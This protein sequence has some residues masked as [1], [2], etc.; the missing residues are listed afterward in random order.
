[1]AAAALA[2]AQEN[3]IDLPV[4]T[5]IVEEEAVAEAQ[6]PLIQRIFVSG[7]QG[8]SEPAEEKIAIF[9][10]D[11]PGPVSELKKRLE[12]YLG[13]EINKE[14]LFAI[15]QSIIAFYSEYQ[16][17]FIA[18]SIPEQPITQGNIEFH[19]VEPVIEQMAVTGNRWFSDASIKNAVGVKEGDAAAECIIMKRLAW[20]NMNP[21]IH[22]DALY[23]PG[24]QNGT[25]RLNLATKDRFPMR[26]YAGADNTGSDPTGD[27]RW[28]AGLNVSLGLQC[29][30]SYQFTSSYK[31]PEFQSHLGNFTFFLPWR[32]EFVAYG[33]YATIHPEIQG[34]KS[35]G[36]DVQG[37]FRYL[38]PIS[39]L[40]KPFRQEFGF[41]FDYKLYNNALFFLGDAEEDEPVTTR[42]CA[43]SQFYLGYRLEDYFFNHHISFRWEVLFSPAEWLPHQSESDYDQLRI[44]A[45]TRYLYSRLAAG[46]VIDLP[47]K[48]EFAALLRLQASTD[49]LLPSEQFGLGG[50]DTVRGY[51]ERIFLA[52]DA[53]CANVEVRSPKISIMPKVKNELRFIAFLDYARG[54]NLKDSPS[55]GRNATLLGVGP[56]LRYQVLPYFTA[57]LDYGF[58]LH[59]VEFD[60][61]RFGRWHF[62]SIL[63]Y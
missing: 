37:S 11:L 26:T 18:V 1:M 27:E 3:A 25:T 28:F 22:S 58:N 39:A 60:P 45:K 56:G 49:P 33:T 21:F 44:G 24:A 57:R 31:F 54:W 16:H 55:E 23:S 8:L 62:S 15:K 29:L 10:L 61:N 19:V 9:D 41:G 13:L 43:I 50:Y 38:I 63:S 5:N 46:D 20:L 30:V 48:F 4:Q 34:F 47:G 14:N 12:I 2:G 32:H 17:P 42:N 35:H 52:D 40:Y 51:L 6:A 36:K 59:E 7:K 53:L